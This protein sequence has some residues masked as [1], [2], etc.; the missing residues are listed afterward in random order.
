[1]VCVWCYQEDQPKRIPNKAS[2]TSSITRA[3]PI[4]MQIRRGDAMETLSA[5]AI[6]PR[7]SLIKDPSS[8][9]RCIRGAP[10]P[11]NPI[12]S[13]GLKSDISYLGDNADP[14]P[15]QN[16]VTLINLESRPPYTRIPT[17]RD[18]FHH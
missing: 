8:S 13:G 2:R 16:I 17:L 6:A 3:G 1:M 18:F 15:A 7:N 9:T 4:G 14:P 12:I 10:P 5:A 11:C